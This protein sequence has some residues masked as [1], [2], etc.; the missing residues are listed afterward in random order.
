[1]RN[2]F[3]FD[4]KNSLDYDMSVES[5]PAY[6]IPERVIELFNVPGRNG[7]LVQDSGSFQ[8][9]T[10]TYDVFY[11]P[12]WGSSS[13]QNA[14]DILKW[15]LSGTGYKRLE[16]SYNPELFRKAVYSGSSEI[17]MFFEK[18]GRISLDFNCLPQRFLKIGEFPVDMTNGGTLYNSWEP[19]L[20]LIRVSG[21][22]A[23][24]VTVGKYQILISNITENLTL[25]GDTQNAFD[26]SGNANNLVTLSNGFPRLERGENLVTWSGGVT[27]VL[28]TPRWWKL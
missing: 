9:V 18:Y 13:F 14:N 1:M 22:G 3:I 26:N 16:D 24:T 20:P 10:Q 17:S 12:R 5:Y 6:P 2:Y 11:K 4:G 19:A 7:T 25:D 27:D 15:L 8:N 23:G 21:T 28:I